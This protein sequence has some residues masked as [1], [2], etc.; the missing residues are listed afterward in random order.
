LKP[1][2]EARV[3]SKNIPLLQID[4]DHWGSPVSQQYAIRQLPA[5][6]MYQDGKLVSKSSPDVFR[7]LSNL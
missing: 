6:W 7:R 2:L 5:L 3:R 1:Q 4:I